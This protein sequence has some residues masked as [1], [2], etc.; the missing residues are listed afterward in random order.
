M[1]QIKPYIFWIVC[2]VLLV[3]E[4]AIIAMVEPGVDSK[5]GVGP[6]DA[7]R[8]AEAAYRSRIKGDLLQRAKNV[9]E[10]GGVPS[11]LERSTERINE[12][13]DNYIITDEW[14][15]ILKGAIA[16]HHKQLKDIKIGLVSRSRVLYQPF[17]DTDV[18][19]TWYFEYQEKTADILRRL[20]EAGVLQLP[21]AF[22]DPSDEDLTENERLRSTFGLRTDPNTFL[23]SD[24]EAVVREYRVIEQLAAAIANARGRVYPNP[25]LDSA[26]GDWAMAEA[27]AATA[28]L[29][30]LEW[31]EESRRTAPENGVEH[32]FTLTLEG[33][34]AALH[35]AAA[36]IDR[37]NNPILVRTGCR[38]T[39]AG[40]RGDG[41]AKVGAQADEHMRLALN[42]VLLDY[43]AAFRG[44]S[45]LP[46]DIFEPPEPPA[47]PAAAEAESGDAAANGEGGE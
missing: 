33:P 13:L 26:H 7:K 14:Q 34:P 45:G 29:V 20:R 9:I 12:V 38:W 40:R 22:T 17:T 15:T 24:H 5:P 43:L 23:A 36:A 37:I 16:E 35:A 42:Y 3:I 4:L 25:L 30:E 47:P 19:A 32:G 41:S 27:S 10:I 21:S 39:R 6:A 1:E 46:A 31:A 18:P 8:Q 2:G 11:P 44:D 28:G